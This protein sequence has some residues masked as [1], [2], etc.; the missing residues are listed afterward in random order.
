[1]D[2]NINLLALNHTQPN[3][4]YYR[5]LFENGFFQCINLASRFCN[6]SY[7]AIDHVVTNVHSQFITTGVF[8]TDISDHLMTF[9]ETADKKPSPPKDPPPS[10]SFP[11]HKI[12]NFKTDLSNIRWGAVTDERDT[13]RAFDKFWEIFK[14]LLELHFPIRKVKFNKNFHK[15]NGYMTQGLLV[16]RITKLKLYKIQTANPSA[17]NIDNYKNYRNLYNKILRA[18][19]KMYFVGGLENAKRNPKKTWSLLK[20]ALNLQSNNNTIQKLTINGN[21]TIIPSEIATGFN[22]HFAGAGR[23]VANS[24]PPS[25]IPIEHFMPNKA[26]P[27]FQLGRTNPVEVCDII[28]AFESKTSSDMNGL[29]MKLIKNIRNEISVPLA[30]IFN[31]SLTQGKFPSKLKLSR[32]VPIHK[33]GRMDICDN[34]RPIALQSNIS[35]IL[36]KFVCIRLVNHLELNKIIHPH[37]FGFQRNK[38]TQHNL[39]SLFNYISN[40]LNEGDY[41]IGP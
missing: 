40:A 19:R 5:I 10:R 21:S 17:I 1:L 12:N 11:A 32:V 16:S 20:E 4:N 37:Q 6:Q 23:K 38:N 35:K 9:I 15:I 39:L 29:S 26:F 30:H 36:E 2:S 24:I 31:L 27:N 25:S 22:E 7:T 13:D 34:Y 41:C 33:A 3:F 14:P 18:S 8:L 28:K